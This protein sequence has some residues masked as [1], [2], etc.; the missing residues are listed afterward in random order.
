MRCHRLVFGFAIAGMLSTM[1]ALHAEAPSLRAQARSIFKAL[2]RD[3]ATAENPITPEKVEL[4]RLLFF[5]PRIS[6]DGTV[7][8]ARCHQPSLYWVQLTGEGLRSALPVALFLIS[9]AAG[10]LAGMYLVGLIPGGAA[11]LALA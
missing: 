10:A 1:A 8:C 4:G 2:P 9:L 5:D 11:A 3:M 6:V 7:S